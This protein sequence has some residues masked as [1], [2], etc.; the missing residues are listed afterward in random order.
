MA[1]SYNLHTAFWIIILF[2]CLISILLFLCLPDQVELVFPG[3][4]PSALTS[5]I[6]LVLYIITF[7]C[8]SKYT[9]QSKLVYSSSVHEHFCV[10]SI[11]G[12][13]I[14]SSFLAGVGL[15]RYSD[16]QESIVSLIYYW[17]DLFLV[18]TSVFGF[19][20]KPY[21]LTPVSKHFLIL[22]PISLRLFIFRYVF[23]LSN[24]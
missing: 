17:F 3:I 23:P 13:L 1:K 20:T 8:Y 4:K 9:R 12:L 18:H 11:V 16:Y 24:Y 6:S 7:L 15:N 2:N 22:N 19:S 14:C 21:A 10:F 5:S